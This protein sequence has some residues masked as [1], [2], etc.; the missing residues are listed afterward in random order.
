MFN[1]NVKEFT[2]GYFGKLPE[3]NDFIK[4]NAGSSEILF[5]DNWLQEGLAYT[6]SKSKT[7]WKTKYENL[8]PTG[9]YIPVT[10]SVKAAAGMLYT[11]NDKSGRDFPFLIFSLLS[12]KQV[13]DFYLIPSEL[14]QTLA[15]LD[16][17]LRSEDDLQSL[18]NTLR[19]CNIELSE[20]NLLK[21]NFHKY[22]SHT[23]LNEFLLRTK[24]NNTLQSIKNITY[25]NSAFVRI[26][27]ISDDT[28]FSADAGFI[29]YLLAKKI[30]LSQKQSS[31]FWNRNNDGQFQ[32]YIFPFK[33]LPI[34]FSDLISVE[35]D[36]N[37]KL[38]LSFSDE[39]INENNI[40]NSKSLLEFLTDF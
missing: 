24:L 28:H 31:I 36:D 22:L 40:D 18:N 30:N 13:V 25:N 37:R 12:F 27:F 10:S 8:P 26:S 35:S 11:S 16:S 29:I 21:N 33:L 5:I 38:D 6:K 4:F 9:F 39:Y 7:D 19:S 32:V 3:F 2:I 1:K 23:Q 34:N 15:V 20:E 17:H 14:E